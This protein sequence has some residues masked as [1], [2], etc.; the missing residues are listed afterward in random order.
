MEDEMEEI[1]PKCTCGKDCK[2]APLNSGSP[3]QLNNGYYMTC[4]NLECRKGRKHR[5]PKRVGVK[6]KPKQKHL[7]IMNQRQV[8]DT[9]HMCGEKK[10]HG[11]SIC[12]KCQKKAYFLKHR[13][14][15]NFLKRVFSKPTKIKE[16]YHKR[17]QEEAKEFFDGLRQQVKEELK[18]KKHD[19]SIIS[20]TIQDNKD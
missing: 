10:D 17:K 4:G 11:R 15:D 20:Q 3:A 9:C 5:H 6:E 8:S 14:H 18:E 16:A 12:E 7:T 19:I 13:V 2:K 1:V